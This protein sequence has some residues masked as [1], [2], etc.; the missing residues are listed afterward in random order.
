MQPP[1]PCV[2]RLP[3]WGLGAARGAAGVSGAARQVWEVR[4]RV[5]A[6]SAQSARRP[7]GAAGRLGESPVRPGNPRFGP[8]RRAGRLRGP[9]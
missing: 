4:A 3:R 2:G 9:G 8:Q 7:P 6:A 5:A 1:M